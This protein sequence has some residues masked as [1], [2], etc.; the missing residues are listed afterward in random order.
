[1]SL[2]LIIACLMAVFLV[3]SGPKIADERAG[4]S[5]AILAD[6][7]ED[8]IKADEQDPICITD[9]V[10]RISREH[11]VSP[12]LV[13]AI[14][15]VES[16]GNPKAVS[17]KGAL[18][19]MQLMPVL[20]DA[21]QIADPFDPLA[22]VEA[23]VRHLKYLLLEFSGDVSM[24]LAAYNAGQGTV[25]RYGGVPPYPETR[26]FLQDVLREFQRELNELG[27]L[28]KPLRIEKGEA[29][30]RN[31]QKISPAKE[32][33]NLAAFQQKKPAPRPEA[34]DL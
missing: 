10:R 17:K 8:S 16:Q 2:R 5:A 15:Q 18:G 11:G 22:N 27:L 12:Q 4:N 20:I 13:N 25:R 34:G 1:M 7:G 28:V 24:A 33:K 23:G 21:Y 9:A 19:L 6:S 32:F 14:I 26:L 31:I 3:L 30:E 29:A